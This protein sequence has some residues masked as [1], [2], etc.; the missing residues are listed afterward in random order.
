MAGSSCYTAVLD[1]CVLYP[2]PLRDLL[3]SLAR[4]GLF[5][6]R[7]TNRIHDE[8]VRNLLA[9][10]SDLTESQLR[11][12]CQLMNDAVPDSLIDR[13]EKLEGAVELPDADDR[14]V[15]AAAICGHADAIVT[16]N[17][18]DFPA[19]ALAQFGVEALHPDDFLLNQID[20][21]EIQALKAIKAMRARLR[22]PPVCGAD[23]I[24][25]L[26]KLQLPLSAARLKAAAELI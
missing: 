3:L 11:R 26:E 15:L 23:L 13:W 8:W 12:T 10:R 16:Y 17:L 6:A 18:D 5:H 21:A 9:N 1:A 14:H 24:V 20:L 4:E 19:Q 22:N 7:W 2:A 25:T